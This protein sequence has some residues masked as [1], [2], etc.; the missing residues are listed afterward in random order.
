[1]L[2]TILFT[3]D[4]NILEMISINDTNF[5]EFIDSSSTEEKSSTED[6]R[7]STAATDY[8]VTRHTILIT[9][10]NILLFRFILVFFSILNLAS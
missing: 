8:Q 10:K 9:I 5:Q 3:I 1:M 6:L 2:Q 4:D 7:P